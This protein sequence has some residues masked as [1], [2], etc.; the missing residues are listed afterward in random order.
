MPLNET[1]EPGLTDG[2][3]LPPGDSDADHRSVAKEG[4]WAGVFSLAGAAIRYGNN[5]ILTRLLGA[6]LYGLYAL[7]NTVV[8]VATVPSAL[9]LPTSLVHFLATSSERGEW[10]RLRWMVR[11]SFRA[12]FLSSLLAAGLVLALAPWLSRSV[13]EKDGLLL[14]LSG[15]AL[16]LPF[17]AL[18]MVCAGGLQG[19]RFIRGKV[20]IERIA[21][22]LVF[23]VLLVAGGFFFRSLE[24]ILVCFFIAA[25]AV[26][27]LG[28][29]WLHRRMSGLPQGPMPRPV[30]REMLGFSTPIMF[31]NLLNF[32][33]LWS[34]I[35]VMGMFRP[36]AEVG[37]YAIAS[38]LA[39]GV[40]MPTDSLGASL[41]PSFSSLTG[42]GD[43]EGL[44]RLFHTSTR[45]IF[46]LSSFAGMGLVLLGHPILGLF[47]SEFQ[48]GYAALCVL[49]LGQVV[50]AL[51]GANGTLITMTGHPRVNLVNSVILGLGN[52][53]LNLL[54]VPR[55]GALG[56]ASAAA[57][58]WAT[59]NTTR[60]VEIWFILKIGPW[61]R[62]ILKP[63]LCLSSGGAV[64]GL[65][66]WAVGGTS[67]GPV[68]PV[69]AGL[70]GLVVFA[71]AWWALR[72][73]PEDLDM[74]RRAVA[75][76]HRVPPAGA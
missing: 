26:L 50:T 51:F 49:A 44:R 45:W 36:A 33:I 70:A 61:D 14:P 3:G 1:A 37:F 40:S 10:G 42:R 30:W 74:I 22:P 7:A 67:S 46:L 17:L 11:A 48:K 9:G 35:L 5:I 39:T 38:R 24:F 12:V 47:G 66:L 41:A 27:T 32:F 8:T 52:L 72:P 58:S 20:F 2:L 19:L 60:A 29:F 4:G 55:Y 34:D 43:G 63:V 62:T 69:L 59:V 73:E 13:F 31:M 15:L 54:L 71:L 28:L 65:L 64:G 56:A 75:R 23:T 25:A 16:A 21:H 68:G 6:K 18:Y 76:V 53:G 57:I